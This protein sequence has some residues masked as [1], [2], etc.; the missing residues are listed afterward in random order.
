MCSGADKPLFAIAL[1]RQLS[2]E[3]TIVFTASLEATRR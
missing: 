1:L 2:A 3:P